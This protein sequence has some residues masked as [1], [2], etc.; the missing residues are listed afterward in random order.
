MPWVG[1]FGPPVDLPFK[2]S[3]GCILGQILLLSL[4]SSI[5]FLDLCTFGNT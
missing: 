2:S 3:G 4:I 1:E 5:V